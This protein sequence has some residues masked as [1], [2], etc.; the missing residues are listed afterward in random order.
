MKD[1]FEMSDEAKVKMSQNSDIKEEKDSN[2]KNESEISEKSDSS[3][4]MIDK[5]EKEANEYRDKFIRK[6]AEFDN[7][8]RRKENELSDYLK[9]ANEGLMK[10][11]LPV[12]DDLER[13][14]N[15]S[16]NEN[17]GKNLIEGLEMI[18][19]KFIKVLENY[20]LTKIDSVGKPFDVNFHEAL[21][22]VERPDVPPHSVVEEILKGYLL[23]ERVLRHTKVIVSSDRSGEENI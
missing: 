18:N 5:L 8:K 17:S 7:F 15:Y 11:L 16:K 13:S 19:N 22:Q 9:Y 10:D 6:M 2:K 1:K 20:G 3:K 23:K 21:L 4:E 14:V 12:L